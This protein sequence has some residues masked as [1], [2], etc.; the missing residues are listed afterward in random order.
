MAIAAEELTP[1]AATAV[2]E[3]AAGRGKRLSK[4][5][6]GEL[7]KRAARK[8]KAAESPTP[9]TPSEPGI[10]SAIAS[11]PGKAAGFVKGPRSLSQSVSSS[12]GR[13]GLATRLILAFGAFLLA[14]E[15][16]SFLSG[17]YFSYSLTKGGQ[18]LQGAAQSL[19]LYPGQ[20]QKLALQKTLP[21][22]SS[23]VPPGVIQL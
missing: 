4:E 7:R 2:S 6:A 9:S 8:P 5:V 18:K 14:L 15:L 12:S 23:K 10:G 13:L 19:D 17:R 11:A 1:A 22:S 3:A 21:A 20:S 16:A